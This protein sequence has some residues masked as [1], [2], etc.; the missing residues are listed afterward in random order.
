MYPTVN[1]NI[2]KLDNGYRHNLGISNMEK[3][4]DRK[5][6]Q[7]HHVI[8]TM[9]KSGWIDEPLYSKIKQ[10]MPI[11][12]VDLLITYNDRLLLMKR[13]NNPAKGKWFTPGGRIFKNETIINAVKRVLLEETGLVSDSITQCGTMSHVWSDVQ[14]IT[15]FHK[16]DAESDNIV[17]NNEHDALKWISEK[18]P[19]L[20]PYLV[21][22]INESNI[23]HK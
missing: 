2:I 6:Y 14:T 9:S 11:P 21:H 12:C 17:M 4:K 23:F 8:N 10:R 19:S 16:V 18:E 13:K 5:T 20:H 7:L 15:V 3:H 22:M 1:S